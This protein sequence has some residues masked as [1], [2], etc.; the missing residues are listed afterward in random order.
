MLPYWVNFLARRSKRLYFMTSAPKNFTPCTAVGFTGLK[1]RL[2]AAISKVAIYMV[3]FIF[4]LQRTYL[5]VK[6]IRFMIPLTGPPRIVSGPGEKENC[7]RCTNNKGSTKNLYVIL[8]R[9]SITQWLGLGL[10]GIIWKICKMI[11]SI[12]TKTYATYSGPDNLYRLPLRL[13]G[14]GP[15]QSVHKGNPNCTLLSSYFTFCWTCCLIYFHSF[16]LRCLSLV[17]KSVVVSINT[18]LTAQTDRLKR[19]L[20]TLTLVVYRTVLISLRAYLPKN[21]RCKHSGS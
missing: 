8:E 3:G 17:L 16:L 10:K 12:K 2:L 1:F 7:F 6:K 20:R 21:R 11:P 13:V 15:C 4:G 14:T 9:P 19:K 5:H 18:P